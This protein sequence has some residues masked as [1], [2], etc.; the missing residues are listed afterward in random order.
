MPLTPAKPIPTPIAA[1]A[2]MPKKTAAYVLRASRINVI[3]KP[4]IVN[5]T[6]GA[7]MLP[8]W[9]NVASLATM[10]PAFFKPMK[11]MKKPMPA[12]IASFSDLGIALTTIL[13]SGVTDTTIP[14]MPERKT[15]AKASGAE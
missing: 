13:R 11:A 15:A 10:M 2:T 9:T 3:N 1:V 8:S 6:K 14:T 7:L 4:T 12:P 5:K